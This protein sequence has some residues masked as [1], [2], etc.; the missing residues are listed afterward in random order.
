MATTQKD[1]DLLI[2]SDDATSL[3]FSFVEEETEKKPETPIEENPF[4]IQENPFSIE[5]EATIILEEEKAEEPLLD[6]SVESE[7]NNS[8]TKNELND[9]LKK[10]EESSDFII[11]EETKEE[12]KI[13]EVSFIEEEPKVEEILVSSS[14]AEKN[15][16]DMT[17]ILQRTIWEFEQRE[18]LI[19]SD[20][21]EKEKHISDLEKELNI[22]K[23][24]V[25]DLKSEKNALEKNRKSLEKMKKDFEKKDEIN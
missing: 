13:S 22:E 8:E 23:E 25:S 12:P 18:N 4:G 6:F 17:D 20:I 16:W 11:Q 15:L 14:K 7:K 3:D 9:I 19:D 1:D 10:V 24:L 2:L 21:S 5:P